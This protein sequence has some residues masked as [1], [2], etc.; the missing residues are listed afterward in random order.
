MS[1]HQRV[2][3]CTAVGVLA[4]ATA[5][6]ADGDSEPMTAPRN[7]TDVVNR[8]VDGYARTGLDLDGGCVFEVLSP[9]SDAVLAESLAA[10]EAGEGALDDL[11][12][13]L[14]ADLI[15]CDPAAVAAAQTE[16]AAPAAEGRSHTT[17]TL[18]L[19]GVLGS[20]DWLLGHLT[21][22]LSREGSLNWDCLNEEIGNFT[23]AQLDEAAEAIRAGDP[24]T[25]QI[26]IA[27]LDKTRSDCVVP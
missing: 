11:D 5:G 4:L 2:A 6:C 7:M 1:R 15:R 26:A 14:S 25:S 17:T 24:T 13:K 19:F 23:D 27:I 3:A 16:A 9:Y 8:F 21:L 10:I 12:G 22:L 18:D 20:R